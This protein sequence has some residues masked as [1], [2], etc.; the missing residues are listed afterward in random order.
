MDQEKIKKLAEWIKTNKNYS[1]EE[2]RQSAI[3]SG[4]SE[5][6]FNIALGVVYASTYNLEYKG[7]II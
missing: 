6:D 1:I 4:V 5:E 7:V 2:L 3:Q